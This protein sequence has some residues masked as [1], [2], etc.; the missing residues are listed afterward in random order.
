MDSVIVCYCTRACNVHT[1]Q[2]CFAGSVPLVGV[3]QRMD[4]CF[5]FGRQPSAVKVKKAFFLPFAT[6]PSTKVL[7]QQSGGCVTLHAVVQELVERE[8]ARPRAAGGRPARHGERGSPPASW[9]SAAGQRFG[10]FFHMRMP[11]VIVPITD[12]PL[13]MSS[14]NTM[15]MWMTANRTRYHIAR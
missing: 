10:S 8:A 7:I 3:V 1:M 4:T 15:Y 11:L 5:N 6:L 13:M 2:P 9:I 14:R 12:C